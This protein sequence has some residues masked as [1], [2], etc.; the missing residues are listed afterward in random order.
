CKTAQQGIHDMLEHGGPKIKPVIL[1]LIIP[2]NSGDGIDYSQQK[3][4]NVG[5]LIQE[6]GGTGV[7]GG[8]EAFIN[9]KYMVP[10]Y[11][12]CMINPSLNMRE[13]R[14]GENYMGRHKQMMKLYL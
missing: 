14:V 6:T 3:G 13:G 1:Q 4:Q 5:E 11:E 12:S 2:I 7:L 9:I 8:E 10:T